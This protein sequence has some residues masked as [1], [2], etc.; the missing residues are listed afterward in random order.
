MYKGVAMWTASAIP[1]RET[2]CSVNVKSSSCGGQLNISLGERYGSSAVS[3][4]FPLLGDRVTGRSESKL[5][6]RTGTD[7]QV[8]GR[9]GET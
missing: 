3:L 6:Q 9:S 1:V 7:E 8:R 4:K 2:T 5:K